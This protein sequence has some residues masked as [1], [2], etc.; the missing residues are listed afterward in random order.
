[1]LTKRTEGDPERVRGVKGEEESFDFER[2]REREEGGHYWSCCLN[3]RESN[4]IQFEF[5]KFIYHQQHRRDYSRIDFV[6]IESP[7]DVIS[8]LLSPKTCEEKVVECNCRS[9]CKEDE[10]HSSCEMKPSAIV[11]LRVGHVVGNALSPCAWDNLR[12]PSGS[13]SDHDLSARVSPPLD[14]RCI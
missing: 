11:Y 1:M 13:S 12:C 9:L 7:H 2:L 6:R 3:E 10:R 14:F 4:S 5:E 8:L